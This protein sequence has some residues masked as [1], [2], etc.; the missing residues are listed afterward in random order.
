[1]NPSA[2][3]DI[4]PPSAATGLG[5]TS[6]TL[7]PAGEHHVTGAAR[8]KLVWSMLITS[9]ALFACYM[10][11]GSVL[12]PAQVNELD[13]ANKESNLA[14]VTSISS[15]ATMFIQPLVGALSD[16]TRSKLGRRAPWMLSGAILGGIMLMLL[17]VL[18][19]NVALIALFWVLAQVSLNALQGPLSALISDR[20]AEDFRATA[21]GF[22]GVGTSVGMAVGIAV[23]GQF[24]TRLGVGYVTV[25]L[26]VII[27]TIALILLNQDRSSKDLAVEP[28][29]LG[30]FLKGFWV[31]PRLHPDFA[32]AFAQRFA[33]F[34]GSVG[35]AGYMFYI[36]LSYVGMDPVAAGAF[37]GVQS[38]VYM[39]SSV[40]ATFIAGPLSDKLRRRKLFVFTSSMLIAIAC[41]IP[42]LMPTTTGII[43]YSVLAGAGFGAYL[44]V[45]V[46]LVV[47]VLPSPEEAA[48]CLGIINIANNIPQMLSPILYAFFA[49]TVGYSA[50]WVW[51]IVI[52]IIASFLVLP[53][54]KVR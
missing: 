34:L 9:I 8:H 48:K 6:R 31:S 35:I 24:V 17:P 54:K 4:T 12:L 40:I 29:C 47:D 22:I 7:E 33:M 14:I 42:L 15:F 19:R 45:D 38:F 46:A 30:S 10:A 16:R 32:W 28:F 5:P 25:A 41:V 20:L 49:A 52:V 18:G 13:P 27:T 50:I 21:S 11:A 51:G 26:A 23:A 2:T 37:M 44:A 39:T 3:P 36:L 53:I 43:L 1:M